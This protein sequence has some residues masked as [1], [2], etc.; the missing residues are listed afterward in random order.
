MEFHIQ[1]AVSLG[2]DYGQIT[3]LGLHYC[4][5]WELFYVAV[6]VLG[7]ELYFGRVIKHGF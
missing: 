3:F 5:D 4:F 2:R 1:K 7:V 6:I